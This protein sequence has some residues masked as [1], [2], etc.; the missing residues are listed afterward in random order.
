MD[1]VKD[2]PQENTSPAAICPRAAWALTQRGQGP[3][4]NP[5]ASAGDEAPDGPPRRRHAPSVCPTRRA[6]AHMAAAAHTAT[7]NTKKN[8][9]TVPRR[10]DGDARGPLRGR[11]PVRVQASDPGPWSRRPRM[12]DP[13]YA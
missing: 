3:L 6:A 13:R 7:D 5:T 9:P 11:P 1:E 10:E 8:C 4:P 2:H 12:T